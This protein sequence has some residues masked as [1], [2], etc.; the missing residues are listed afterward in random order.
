MEVVG[1]QG[2]DTNAVQKIVHA[3]VVVV[4]RHQVLG[5]FIAIHHDFFQQEESMMGES[6]DNLK[7]LL[8]AQ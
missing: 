1:A 7:T 4:V 3:A 5:P 6:K 8:T 2:S